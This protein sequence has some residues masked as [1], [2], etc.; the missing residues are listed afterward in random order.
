MHL[1]QPPIEPPQVFTCSTLGCQKGAGGTRGSIK[2]LAHVG[3]SVPKC[4]LC[5]AALAHPLTRINFLNLFP[6]FS[7]CLILWVSGL[8]AGRFPRSCWK[9]R[10]TAAGKRQ[11]RLSVLTACVKVSC[12]R[13]V[14][15]YQTHVLHE[16]A[17]WLS[18]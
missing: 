17:G 11:K 13:T 16:S 12:L 9:Q 8:S 18:L 7:R 14:Q 6:S 5:L 1:M 4:V 10:A 15:W 3:C 2:P